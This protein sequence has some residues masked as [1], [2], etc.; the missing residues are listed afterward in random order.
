VA[1]CAL[2]IH[3]ENVTVTELV[4][5]Y[6]ANGGILGEAAYVIGK[7]FGRAHCSL[8]DVT[9]SPIRRKA[10]WDAFVADCGI[11][12]RLLHLNELDSDLSRA[13]DGRSPV[14][15]GRSNGEWVRVL[16]PDDI[17]AV[18]GDVAQFEGSLAKRLAAL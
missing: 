10:S 7:V 5:V 8:C 6:H 11:P 4:G 9:H 14:V 13:V 3:T 18:H 15:L 16:E 12:F 2:A 1:D 17:D